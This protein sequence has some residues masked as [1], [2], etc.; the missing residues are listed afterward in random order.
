MVLISS[1]PPPQNHTQKPKI[2][3][4]NSSYIEF[5]NDFEIMGHIIKTLFP[6]YSYLYTIRYY[7]KRGQNWLHSLLSS[8]H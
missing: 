4:I 5:R 2:L 8:F 7:Q 1:Y 3:L 6:I